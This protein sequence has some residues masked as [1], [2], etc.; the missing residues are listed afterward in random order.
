MTRSTPKKDNHMSPL[1]PGDKGQ[2]AEG[3]TNIRT[4]KTAELIAQKRTAKDS[5]VTN[6]I[7]ATPNAPNPHCQDPGGGERN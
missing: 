5:A 3:I 4:N 7:D 6:V 2:D 1:S